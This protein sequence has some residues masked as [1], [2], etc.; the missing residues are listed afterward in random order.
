[1]TEKTSQHLSKI[2]HRELI[3]NLREKSTHWWQENIKRN[4]YML[5]SKTAGEQ[6]QLLSHQCLL[7]FY[8]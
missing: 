2:N 1:M 7:S 5:Q 3:T 8:S 6:C 4:A